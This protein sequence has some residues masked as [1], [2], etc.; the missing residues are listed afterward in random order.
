MRRD[1]LTLALTMTLFAAPPRGFPAAHSVELI[2]QAE[3]RLIN[4]AE[5]K[6]LAATP[7]ELEAYLVASGMKAPVLAPAVK[8][9]TEDLAAAVAG[10]V[11]ASDF[12]ASRV[13][14][15]YR[16]KAAFLHY[17]DDGE[18]QARLTLLGV[19]TEAAQRYVVITA[20]TVEAK[21][22]EDVATALRKSKEMVVFLEKQDGAWSTA[23]VPAPPPP[24]CAAVLKSALKTIS[25]AEKAYFAEFDA[26]SNSLKK[27]G[28]D[29]A[30]LGITS[31]K[32][33][34]T[35]A[36]PQQTFVAQVG[37]KGGLMSV[38]DKGT[39][40]VLSDCKN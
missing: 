10:P 9:A 28:V 27:V 38:D 21:S 1:M 24:D 14:V 12:K 36:A 16:G 17:F 11:A 26:Y 37:L 20:P 5:L 6:T 15:E 25:I 4:G 23:S 34:V 8:G 40:T 7:K 39:V 13:L 33:T 30:A 31:A 35:G 2:T 18:R 19:G 3:K 32:V 22:F 29:A